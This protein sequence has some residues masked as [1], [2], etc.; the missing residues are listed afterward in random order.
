M[1]TEQVKKHKEVISWWL[2]NT[3]KGVYRKDTPTNDWYLDLEPCWYEDYD[4]VQN[5]EYEEFRK[6]LKD[7]KVVQFYSIPSGKWVDD[8]CPSFL[9]KPRFY[10]IKPE[11]LKPE[12]GDWVVYNND[13]VKIRCFADDGVTAVLTPYG[14]ERVS[15][16]TKWTPTVGEYCWFYDD[17]EDTPRLGKF[18][19][20][21]DNDL[22][23]CK[24]I[25][26]SS[27]RTCSYYYCEP[28]TNSLPTSI[29]N[30]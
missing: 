6:A 20:Y 14:N 19:G 24:F 23:I 28:F 18:D 26:N 17:K 4:Y 30:T 15:N 1:T 22:P 25:S 7:N 8:Y 29:Q 2:Q 16:L 13:I 27:P 10:R 11:E 21:S 3:D 9:S 12:V 5:D